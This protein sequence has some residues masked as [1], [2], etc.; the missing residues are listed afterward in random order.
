VWAADAPT[1][2]QELPTTL[3]EPPELVRGM[4]PDAGPRFERLAESPEWSQ[5]ERGVA[6]YLQG[7]YPE[8][9]VHFSN[10]LREH[11]EPKLTSSVQAYLAESALKSGSSEM[12]PVEIIE[13]YRTLIREDPHSTNAKRAAW[14]IGDIYR[15]EGWCQEA[16]IAYQ[17][18][19]GLS[20]HDSYD[21]N[22]AM[23]GLG[24]AF[25]GLGKWKESVQTFDN[26]LKRTTDPSLL[27]FASLGQAHSLY[28][29]ARIKEADSLY[30]SLAARWPA[31]FRKDPYALL[32]YADTA[33]EEH[34]PSV[35]REQLLR[36][37][38]LYPSRPENPFVLAHIA[39]SY[40]EA[41][42]WE[43]ASRFYAALFTQFRDAP[44]AA[45]AALRYADVLDHRDP[46]D[47]L[48]HVRQTVTA[49]L[50][51]IPL[52]PGESFSPR[53]LFENSARKY[54]NSVVGSEAIFRLGEAFE[55]AGKAEE[56]VAAYERVVLRAGKIEND[57]WPDRSGAQLVKFL[58][59]R[60]EAALKSQDDFEL[61]NLFH[62]HGPLADRLYAGSEVLLKIADA[63]QRLG[64]PVEAARL[65][66][67]V[68]RDPKAES[69]HEAAIMGLGRSY[70][71]QR[72]MRAA[73]SVFERYRLQ[74]P[75]G[76]FAGEALRGILACFEGEGNLAGLIK[77]GRQW[78]EH[79]PRHVDR[80]PVLL[81]MANALGQAKQYNE[82]V[83]V[84]DAIDKEGMELPAGDLVRY[85]DA[86]VHLKRPEPA[87]SLYKKALV[88]GLAPE[89]DTWSQF[90]VVRLAHY[91]KRKD[92]ALRG[93]RSLSENDDGLVRRMA[94]VLQSDQSQFFSNQ[95]AR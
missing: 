36:F 34:R 41:G 93:F 54:K 39:D 57:P 71:E 76:R 90:Q 46:E 84:Y 67:A 73:R 75:M 42:R 44:I 24:Y 18:A 38:N 61:V 31:L 21:A 53:R 81:Q 27:A 51:N 86:L 58:R 64:F 7:K 79:H 48:V 23:L 22:R 85:A 56:A 19:L 13:L 3:P 66:Q 55:R 2:R 82:A 65:Y 5:F 77:L 63:H 10:M 25:R 43:E 11:P 33:G 83:A 94:A 37:Y 9:R 20:D 12:R 89:Q 59:P 91:S 17:H 92:L 15:A 78:L 70:L 87:L 29:L 35:M 95:E 26:V 28:R 30:E 50:S 74:F 40:K 45:M 72:D 52:A 60:I 47:G 8:A 62:R 4:L 80:L 6:L 16:Q 49:Q 69:W 32:R 1:G 88:T 14:K 68:I